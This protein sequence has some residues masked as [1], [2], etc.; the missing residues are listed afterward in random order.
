MDG[1]TLFLTFTGTL[2][3]GLRLSGGIGEAMLYPTKDD[4]LYYKFLAF[5]LLFYIVI[6]ILFINVV[7]GTILHTFGEL[8]TKA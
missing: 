7:F 6:N 1:S 8:R 4:D 5:T 2:N 3:Y